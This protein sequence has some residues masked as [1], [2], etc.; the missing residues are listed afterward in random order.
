LHGK[1]LRSRWAN[2]FAGG[3]R[4]GPAFL[5]GAGFCWWPQT[6]ANAS[7]PTAMETWAHF[8]GPREYSARGAT[9]ALS[10]IGKQRPAPFELR[11]P[12]G[13]R[14]S[15]RFEWPGSGGATRKNGTAR[16]G[17]ASGERTAS[18]T[19]I[20]HLNGKG[21][22]VRAGGFEARGLLFGNSMGRAARA[23]YGEATLSNVRA[24]WD[25]E[26][27]GGPGATRAR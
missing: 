23:G 14:A 15:I 7:E 12:N 2:P 11:P 6:G 3:P 16:W 13:A 10:Y 26:K 21:T 9:L 5:D 27:P 24:R 22:V 25:R 1:T 4:V 18:G 19:S 17:S 20:Y 8:G